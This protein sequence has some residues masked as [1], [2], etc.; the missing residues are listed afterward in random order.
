[1]SPRKLITSLLIA[2]TLAGCNFN[3]QDATPTVEGIVEEPINPL[4][5][6]SPTLSPTPTRTLTPAAVVQIITLPPTSTLP[7]TATA[8]PEPTLGPFEYTIQS[9]DDLISIVQRFGYREFNNI[10]TEIVRLNDNMSNPDILPPPGTVLLIPRPTQVPMVLDVTGAATSERRVSSAVIGDIDCHTVAE[11]EA[12]VGI[13]E[14][15][16]IT[17][18]IISQLNPD[19][20]FFGC[21]FEE[22]SGGP[23]CSP[24]IVVGTCINV[25]FPTATPTLTLT[26]SGSETPTATP[27]LRAPGLIS[28]PDGS[29]VTGNVTLFWDSVGLLAADEFYLVQVTD[30]TTGAVWPAATK[31]TSIMIDSSMIPTNGQPHVMEWRVTIGKQ[32]ASGA[33]IPTGAPGTA[34]TFRW[35]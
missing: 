4:P 24:I 1:M 5:E 29:R 23:N 13:A 31:N 10:I 30:T 2:L 32:D 14:Q 35:E 12:L 33:Y 6:I 22:P 9:G 3:T 19:I 25:P 16:G 26:P 27:T 15:Y 28:P 20:N 18:E 11:N 8:T 21:N 34:R 17:L 7:P